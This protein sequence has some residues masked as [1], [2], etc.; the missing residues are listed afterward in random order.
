M[1]LFVEADIEMF[2]C[3][4]S[5]RS[6]STKPK[7]EEEEEAEPKDGARGDAGQLCQWGAR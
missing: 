3:L 1:C 4:S 7:P 5:L 2:S 6:W